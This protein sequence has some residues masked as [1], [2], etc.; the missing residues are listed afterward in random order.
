MIYVHL[1]REINIKAAVVTHE[2][3]TT[4]LIIHN[5][6]PASNITTR[7]PVIHLTSTMKILNI[8][9]LVTRPSVFRS[10]YNML[11]TIH[12]LMCMY[13]EVGDRHSIVSIHV[14]SY[15]R[16]SFL[17]RNLTVRTDKCSGKTDIDDFP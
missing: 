16:C 4:T 11:S 7:I 8:S 6:R 12:I 9:Q 5:V 17:Q 3:I 15:H 13:Y 14:D 2:Y 10:Y 1:H